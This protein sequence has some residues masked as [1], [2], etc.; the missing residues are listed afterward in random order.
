[1][2]TFKPI[3]NFQPGQIEELI[4]VCYRGLIELFPAE[5]NRFYQQW[6]YE[7]KLAFQNMDTIGRNAMFTCIDD[8]PIGYFSWDNR[9]YPNGI[10]GQ[11]C[12]LPDYQRLGYGKAQIELIKKIFK[13]NKFKTITAITGDHD[14]FNPAQKMYK[15]CGFDIHNRRK[16]DL[17][18][19]IEYIGYL[20][21]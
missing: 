10:I 2:T 3:D 21:N 20:N 13:D 6:E 18:N 7:D 17:F 8:S 14:F 9:H 11:N 12:I 16:G 19:L 15:E 4:K 5:K 1:M